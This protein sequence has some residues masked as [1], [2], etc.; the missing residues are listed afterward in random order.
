MNKLTRMD[1]EGISV[2]MRIEGSGPSLLFLGGSN[3]DLSLRAPIFESD[4]I[5]HF[6]VAAANPRGLGGTDGPAGEW[7]MHDYATDSMHV[8]DALGWE[9][10]Y[11]LGESFGA[12]TALHLAAMAPQRITQMALSVG[13]A[14]GE[15][16]SSYPIH[17]F[18][19]I[20]DAAVRAQSALEIQDS[21]FT[22]TISADAESAMQTIENRIKAD[23]AF[24]ASFD[25]AKNYPKLLQARAN[26]DAWNLLPNINIPTMIFAG[27][28]DLQA[29]VDRAENILEALPDARLFVVEGGHNLCFATSD[30]VELLIKHW[31]A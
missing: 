24:L 27:K 9:R 5:K 18:L 13:A 31:V 15:G 30:P 28:Y 4:L 29:P 26:H 23:A 21:R 17:E 22:H 3:T 20:K 12:M 11:I 1:T 6:T 19:N 25:N 10:A 7:S 14:G 8:M 2:N 16:G